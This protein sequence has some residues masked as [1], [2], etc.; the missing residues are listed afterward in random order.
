MC[1]QQDLRGRGEMQGR[2]ASPVMYGMDVLVQ[3]P[4]VQPAMRPVKPGIMQVIQRNYCCQDVCHLCNR[5]VS[6]TQA[7]ARQSRDLLFSSRLES[8]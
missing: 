7:C 2:A 1:A 3:Q 5:A 6:K 8:M 4:A